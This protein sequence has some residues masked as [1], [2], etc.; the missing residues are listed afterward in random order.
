[1]FWSWCAHFCYRSWGFY[2]H[3]QKSVFQVFP[4][5]FLF[6][7]FCIYYITVTQ[8]PEYL[9]HQQTVYKRWMYCNGSHRSAASDWTFHH[10][11]VLGTRRDEN[12]TKFSVDWIKMYFWG[13]LIKCIKRAEKFKGITLKWL[14]MFVRS[15]WE[16]SVCGL[17]LVVMDG[18]AVLFTPARQQP[19]FIY[20]LYP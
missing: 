10:L 19:S 7:G 9:S 11:I 6:Y 3:V 20:S 13:V 17:H 16:L 15:K 1:M 2:V 8:P 14:E 5:S 4:S 18:T 12:G